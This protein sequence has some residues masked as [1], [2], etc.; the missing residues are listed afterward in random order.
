MS[1]LAPFGAWFKRAQVH[2]VD[3]SD[4]VSA[5]LHALHQGSYDLAALRAI[6]SVQA[7]SHVRGELLE[8]VKFHQNAAGGVP[9]PFDCYLTLRGLKTLAIRMDRHSD[10]AASCPYTHNCQA[11]A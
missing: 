9:G 10:N 5:Q 8:T 11:A 6:R 2:S 1:Q 4:F 3:D 7:L